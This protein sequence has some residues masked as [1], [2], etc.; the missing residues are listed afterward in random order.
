MHSGEQPLVKQRLRDRLANNQRFRRH[1]H[2]REARDQSCIFALDQRVD[3]SN[4]ILLCRSGR[5]R[6]PEAGLQ[7]APAIAGQLAHDRRVGLA[8]MAA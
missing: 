5:R 2:L 7:S 6:P 1:Q 4:A 8:S 3:G